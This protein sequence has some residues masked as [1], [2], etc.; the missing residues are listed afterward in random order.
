MLS[1]M[2]PAKIN[3]FLRILHRRDDGFHELASL[4]Q[5]IDL[6][7]TLH[8]TLTDKDCLTCDDKTL[9]LDSS[10]LILKATDLFRRKTGINKGLTV[11]LEKRI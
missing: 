7:D 10:N 4:F 3:L 6:F 8:I 2:S 5:A 11:Y 9:P 1:L